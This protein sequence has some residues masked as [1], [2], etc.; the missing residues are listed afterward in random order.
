M[1]GLS[2][3][4]LSD[5]QL[6]SFL[7]F[8][9][10]A[11][12]RGRGLADLEIDGAVLNLHDGVAIELTVERVEVIVSGAGAVVLEITPVRM[13]VVD[14]ASVEEVEDQNAWL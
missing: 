4:F 9:Q 8:R 12:E 3:V 5:L 10:R 13:V 7:S 11:E 14:E 6:D 1:A 2:H